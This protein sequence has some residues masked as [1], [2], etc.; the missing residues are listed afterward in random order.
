MFGD[1]RASLTSRRATAAR[2]ASVNLDE[3]IEV[4]GGRSDGG[5]PRASMSAR[6][7]GD[8]V[9]AEVDTECLD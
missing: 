7:V 6:G 2:A 8:G 3:L 4:G 5:P 9:L 1:G